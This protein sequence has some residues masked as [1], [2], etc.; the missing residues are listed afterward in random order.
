M[1]TKQT[2]SPAK[3]KGPLTPPCYARVGNARRKTFKLFIIGNHKPILKNIGEAERRRF[4]LV[5][6]VIKPV[7]KDALLDAKLQAEWPGI[8]RWMIDGCL[9]WLKNGLIRPESVVKETKAYFDEQDVFGQWL[10]DCTEGDGSQDW[11]TSTSV[12]F[13]SWKDYALQ[14]GS[15]PGALNSFSTRVE[16]REYPRIRKATFRGFGGIRMAMNISDHDA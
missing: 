16:R 14:A 6:F 4:N 10:Q 3:Q 9:D 11:K 7:E 12:L 15:D 1:V 5:P 8:L 2:R 13:S